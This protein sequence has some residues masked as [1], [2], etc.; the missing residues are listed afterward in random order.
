MG[1]D[2]ARYKVGDKF[3]CKVEIT[4]AEDGEYYLKIKGLGD[5]DGYYEEEDL[6]YMFDPTYKERMKQLRIKELEEELTNL[7]GEDK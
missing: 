6:D 3:D 1:E 4:C 5:L 7:K 2:K